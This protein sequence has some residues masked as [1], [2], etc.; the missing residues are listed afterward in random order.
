MRKE[1]VPTQ[2]SIAFLHSAIQAHLL[3]DKTNVL[4]ENEQKTLK[5]SR[6]V[7]LDEDV[8]EEDDE[9]EVEDALVE[10]QKTMEPGSSKPD[11]HAVVVT[12]Q[13]PPIRETSE[14]IFYG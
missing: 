6:A 11:K 5:E 8:N 12:W 13:D 10:P 7:E 14:R 2:T 4:A 9:A 1:L 3:Q